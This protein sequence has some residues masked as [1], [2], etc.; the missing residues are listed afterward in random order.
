M[1]IP[2][3]ATLDEMVYK[4]FSQLHSCEMAVWKQIQ[5]AAERLS[6]QIGL[7]CFRAS[8]GWLFRFHRCHNISNKNICG[9][10]IV[11]NF[12]I[13][14][15]FIKKMIWSIMIVKRAKFP[16][17]QDVFVLRILSDNTQDSKAEKTTTE[18]TSDWFHAIGGP[19]IEKHQTENWKL[20]EIK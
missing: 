1:Q 3:V 9:E 13:V 17:R 7:T 15:P 12:E 4:W 11:T 16:R 6:K 5:A 19:E 2:S 8:S 20:Q 10:N 18:I 14:K